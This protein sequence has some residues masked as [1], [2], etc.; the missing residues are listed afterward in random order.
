[1]FILKKA[2]SPALVFNC[3]IFFISMLDSGEVY[4]S[5]VK[6]SFLNDLVFL[7]NLGFLEGIKINEPFFLN[8][9]L[10]ESSTR[11]PYTQDRTYDNKMSLDANLV[12]FFC[13]K[14]DLV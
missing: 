5:E 7:M 1:M 14:V 4:C 6:L 8:Y 2:A 10:R 13:Q 9:L 11:Q 12:N 3:F